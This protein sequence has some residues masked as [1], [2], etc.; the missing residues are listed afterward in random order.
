VGVGEKSFATII[1]KKNRV[2]YDELRTLLSSVAADVND[3]PITYLS[4]EDGDFIPLTPSISLH[5]TRNTQLVG[6][7]AA[8]LQNA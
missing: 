2:T 4:E 7:E 1:A 5:P 6:S 8:Q 3:R